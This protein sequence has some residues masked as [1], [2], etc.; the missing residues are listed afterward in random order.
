MRLYMVEPAYFSEP[1]GFYYA[2][3]EED[4]IE[5]AKERGGADYEL[6]ASAVW[7]NNKDFKYRGYVVKD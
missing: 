7:A 1:R 3:N 4:A 2:E 6:I 5:Q